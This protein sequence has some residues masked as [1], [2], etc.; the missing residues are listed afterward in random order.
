MYACMYYK[1]RFA[2]NTNVFHK[3]VT[4]DKCFL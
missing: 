4:L 3:K 1:S 2:L